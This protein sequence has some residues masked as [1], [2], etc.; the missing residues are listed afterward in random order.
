M[1]PDGSL[2]H[3]QQPAICP[4]PLAQL[5]FPAPYSR[6]TS[7]YIPPS[8]DINGCVS[9]KS[10]FQYEK[11][12]YR[13]NICL[14]LLCSLNKL[15]QCEFPSSVAESIVL[16]LKSL[17]GICH[18]QI[19]KKLINEL[20]HTNIRSTHNAIL[21]RW[22]HVSAPHPGHHQAIP[23]PKTGKINNCKYWQKN[24][25]LQCCET[26]HIYCGTTVTDFLLTNVQHYFLHIHPMYPLRTRIHPCLLFSP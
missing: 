2:P 6:K 18:C 12:K 25:S 13:P 10:I 24:S 4:Y 15:N 22:L 8:T 26:A 9:F 16:E 7:A 19:S 1:E 14:C 11:I 20:R 23:Q 21:V 17:I 3:S 5:S